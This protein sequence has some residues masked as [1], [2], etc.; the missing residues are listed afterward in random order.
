MRKQKAFEEA[1]E[2][3]SQERAMTVLNLIE[4]LGVIKD[5]I[6]AFDNAADPNEWRR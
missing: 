2:S 3:E 6:K 1:E 4:G 5:G